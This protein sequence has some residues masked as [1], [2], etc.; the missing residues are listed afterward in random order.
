MVFARRKLR[1]R[2]TAPTEEKYTPPISAGNMR[3]SQ[4]IT[5]F[6]PGAIVDLDKFSGIIASADYWEHAYKDKSGNIPENAKIH[7]KNLERLLGVQYFLAPKAELNEKF[8][9]NYKHSNDVATYRF[10]YIHSCP[11]CGRLAPYWEIGEATT[12]YTTCSSCGLK[13]KLVP[14]RFVVACINGHIE[15]FPFNWWVHHGI[16]IKGHQLKIRYSNKSGGLDSIIIHCEDCGRERTM[17]GCM[18]AKALT[19]YK[20]KGKRPW[21]GR[22]EKVWEPGCEATMQT[23]QRGGSNVYYPVLKSALTIPTHRDPFFSMLDDNPKVIKSYMKAR[24][25]DKNIQEMMLSMVTELDDFLK[26][27]GFDKIKNKFEKY[28]NGSQENSDYSYEVL[29]ENEYD[30]LNSES[31]VLNEDF[32]VKQSHISE[33]FKP[34]FDKIVQVCKLR[35]VMAQVG[36]RRVLSMDPTDTNN[37]ELAAL[38]KFDFIR[39]PNGYI[40]TSI[41]KTHWIPG[42]NLYGEGIF[43]KL[44]IN[45]IHKWIEQVGNRYDKMYNRIPPGSP[46]IKY[47]S[48]QYVL[49]HTLSHLLIRQIVKECG[50]SEASIKERIYSTYPGREKQMAGIL[51]YTSSTASDGSLGGLVR[52]SKNE[53]M[54]KVLRNMIDEAQ[55]CSADPLCIESMAQG[56]NSLNYAACHACTLL[57]ETSCES[58]NSLLDRVSIVG[59]HDEEVDI[60]GFF[61]ITKL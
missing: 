3:R 15:D 42:I 35:E 53:I 56:V 14:S 39:H 28:L 51:I 58:F 30:A 19:G 38:Q 2:N 45:M 17:A 21:G 13:Y 36:F 55:W 25:Q 4:I 60:K 33:A 12:D 5:T 57:P 7:D 61:E 26:V 47:F 10:P 9:K 37:Q 16:Y 46:V 49:L 50:Y 48:E 18:T 54:D 24:N 22:S 31:E 34:Y 8:I 43:L 6:G 27:Y 1:D 11:H 52:M 40:S 44:N 32:H 20:C 59:R 23:L 29:R 41:R